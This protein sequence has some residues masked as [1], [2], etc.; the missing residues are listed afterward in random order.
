MVHPVDRVC[1][2]DKRDTSLVKKPVFTI[3]LEDW[4]HGLHIFSRGHT[5]LP[6]VWW[7]QYKLN[8]YGVKAIFYVLEKFD[9][10]V[11]GMV[12]SLESEGHIIKSHGINHFRHEKADRQPYS[13]LGP[14]GGFYMRILPYWLWK[15]FVKLYGMAYV[16]PHDL[17]EDHPK[18]SNPLMNWKRHV[19]LKTARA[20]VERLLKELSWQ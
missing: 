2:K 13:W 11:P 10:E 8:Q 20:K 17:D 7:L 16:H 15:F 4:N 1:T 5:S 19:G 14:T 3:D 6:S 18:L 9:D 12:K